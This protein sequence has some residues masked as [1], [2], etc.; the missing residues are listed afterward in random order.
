MKKIVAALRVDK[1]FLAISLAY[2]LI[3]AITMMVQNY[4]RYGWHA[5]YN[6]VPTLIFLVVG[7]LLF[8][9]FIPFFY[10]GVRLIRTG[11]LPYFWW[12]AI[13]LILLT[14]LFYFLFATGILYVSR[15]SDTFFRPGFTRFY[16]GRAAFFHLL[17]L[18]ATAYYL[19]SEHR[20]EYSKQISGTLGRKKVTIKANLANWIEA[21]D[22]YL[23]IHY[24]EGVLLKRSTLDRMSRELDPDFI[25][26]HRKYLVNKHQVVGKEKNNRNE[27]LIL[28][29]G[30]RLKVGRSYLPLEL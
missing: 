27:Y 17:Y 28:S 16:F 2:L 14:I 22:H 11:R 9:L 20:R 6:P 5:D 7:F 8:S 21:D 4:I 18:S 19:W 3:V 29:T 23:R 12:Y 25:R 26:I 13:P 30:E 24:E 10:T 1:R 15:Y